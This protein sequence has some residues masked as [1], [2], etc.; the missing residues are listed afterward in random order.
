M[1]YAEHHQHGN[2]PEKHDTQGREARSAFGESRRRIDHDQ[3]LN[4]SIAEA[5][6]RVH[7][8]IGKDIYTRRDCQFRG[9][10]RHHPGR[11]DDDDNDDDS[12]GT[13]D[14]HGSDNSDE[15]QNKEKH[16]N[17]KSDQAPRRRGWE[18]HGKH[19]GFGKHR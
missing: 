7:P 12:N 10:E 5:D 16:N 19:K 8:Q 4:P 1:I 11:D 18:K 15:K 14:D 13:D 6:V 2:H 9:R 17:G 3:P